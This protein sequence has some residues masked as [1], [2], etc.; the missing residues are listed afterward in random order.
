MEGLFFLFGVNVLFSGIMVISALNPVHSVL[1]L[2]VAFTNASALFILLNVEFIALIFL[3]IYVGA[4]AILFLFV[5]MMLNLA[6]LG[7]SEDM[8]NYL[9][10]GLI[11]GIVFLFEIWI[12]QNHQ[13]T[14]PMAFIYSAGINY[15][16]Y[17]ATYT[18]IEIIGRI[19]Y[20]ELYYLFI[21]ASFVLLVA[22]IG[23][24]V[25]THDMGTEIKRQ[26]IFIQTSRQL[27]L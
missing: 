24:I 2:I 20:T 16:D 22:M 25:L 8:S 12:W 18:N 19:L 4:I 26:D 15:W 13:E 7:G 14:P 23:A 27:W 6:D 17:T 10:A 21:I 1:W 3:I 9:L 11:I 5:I